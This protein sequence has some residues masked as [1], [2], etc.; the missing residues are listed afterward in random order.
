MMKRRT[1]ENARIRRHS[2]N[3]S[4]ILIR[5]PVGGGNDCLKRNIEKRE[6]IWGGSGVPGFRCCGHRGDI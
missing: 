3:F 1:S 4:R 5:N 2:T 6:V